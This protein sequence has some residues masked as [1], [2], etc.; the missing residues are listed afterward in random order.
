L[1]G[2]SWSKEIGGEKITI[3]KRDGAS[4]L[5]KFVESVWKG[6]FV[7]ECI[8]GNEIDIEYTESSVVRGRNI[9]IGPGCKYP[10]WNITIH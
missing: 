8:E 7:C 6:S 10:K 2:K 5:K 4:I 1:N 9:N 3:C